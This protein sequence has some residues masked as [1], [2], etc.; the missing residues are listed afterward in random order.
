MIG[1]NLEISRVSKYITFT[2]WEAIAMWYGLW[3][4]DEIEQ[5]YAP[6]AFSLLL[7]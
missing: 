4:C 5:T 2:K 3:I 7:S 1:Y 6:E